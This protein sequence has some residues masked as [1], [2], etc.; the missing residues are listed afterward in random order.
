MKLPKGFNLPHG[1]SMKDAQRAMKA[2]GESTNLFGALLK[3][4]VLGH[5]VRSYI[6][7][8]RSSFPILAEGIKNESEPQS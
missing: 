6:L 7:D 8:H 4:P 5:L 1:V 3:D 2:A